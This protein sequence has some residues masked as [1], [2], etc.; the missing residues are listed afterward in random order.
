MLLET[1]RMRDEG[2]MN[3]EKVLGRALHPRDKQG[4]ERIPFYPPPPLFP[5]PYPQARSPPVRS[6]LKERQSATPYDS[7]QSV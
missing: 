4:H 3:Q 7:Y 1:M 2:G 6:G 5:R